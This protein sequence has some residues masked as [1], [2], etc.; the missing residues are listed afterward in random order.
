MKPTY[1]ELLELWETLRQ[2]PDTS[3]YRDGDVDL[4]EAEDF[5]KDVNELVADLFEKYPAEA[6]EKPDWWD[7]DEED[8]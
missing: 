7:A 2:N 5:W 8:E 1:E 4:F 6:P 3:P